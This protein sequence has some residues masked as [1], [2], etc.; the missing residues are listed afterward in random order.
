M[1]GEDCATCQLHSDLS[2]LLDSPRFSFTSKRF[3]EIA[4]ELR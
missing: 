3:G 2:Q 1:L 4:A